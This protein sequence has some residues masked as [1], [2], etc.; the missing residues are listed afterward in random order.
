M[1]IYGI[2]ATSSIDRTGERVLLEGMDISNVKSFNDE[3]QSSHC[4]DILGSVQTSKMVLSEKDCEDEYQRKCWK[5]V[6]KPFLYVAGEIADMDGHPNAQA[7]A[8]LIKFSTRNPNMPVGF[9]VEGSTLERD[10]KI[11]KRTRVTNISLTIKPANTDCVVFPVIDMTKSMETVALPD[12]YKGAQSGR[13]QF[14]NMPSEKQRILAKSEFIT[15][16]KNLLKSDPSASGVTVLKCWS[17]GEAKMFMKQRLTNK[18]SACGESFSMSD[19]FK[20]LT[21]TE[22]V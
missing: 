20:A 4:F 1:K 17:C 22:P 5:H 14:R 8:A 11:L 12:V 3:H 10:G 19:L 18:C 15:E 7:A 9:S 16:A 21:K 2:A 13:K 6:N